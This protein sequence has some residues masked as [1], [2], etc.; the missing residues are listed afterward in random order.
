MQRSNN[1]IAKPD[2][3]PP[4]VLFLLNGKLEFVVDKFQNDVSRLQREMMFA[5]RQMMFFAVP[6]KMMFSP[7]AVKVMEE[8]SLLKLYCCR[9]QVPTGASHA[10]APAGIRSQRSSFI[11]DAVRRIHHVRTKSERIIFARRANTSFAEGIH[12]FG[13]CAANSNL[14]LS[15][16]SAS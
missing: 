12:H 10:Y 4:G 14:S 7:Q 9:R 8:L 16:Y 1:P 13:I 3:G 6:A 15:H 11:F 5:C 2:A